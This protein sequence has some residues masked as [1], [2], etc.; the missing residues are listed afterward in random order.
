MGL[1]FPRGGVFPGEY[2]VDLPT[3]LDPPQAHYCPISTVGGSV[4]AP[5]PIHVVK[6]DRHPFLFAVTLPHKFILIEIIFN[7]VTSGFRKLPTLDGAFTPPSVFLNPSH[8]FFFASKATNNPTAMGDGY[9]AVESAY[10]KT[11]IVTPELEA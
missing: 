6:H 7:P 5:L 4:N 10:L 8:H 1:N 3:F 11:V 2:C 9:H